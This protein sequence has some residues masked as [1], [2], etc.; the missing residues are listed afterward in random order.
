M[1]ETY[2]QYE[3]FIAGLVKDISKTHR[4]IKFLCSG[5]KC[6]LMG[7]LGQKHQVDVAFIDETFNPPKLVLIECKLK[8][9][10]YPVGP[11]VVKILQFNG[12]D[13]VKNPNY[14]DENLLIICSTSNFTSGAKKLSNA[15]NIKLERVHSC[16]DYT[17][18]YENIILCGV[19]SSLDLKENV[20]CTVRHPDG[21]VD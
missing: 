11:E 15:L 12:S 13:L 9:L 5:A 3:E 17:F 14:P 21:T 8:K 6:T 16:P 1:I 18:K 7:A 2:A 4:K 19:S 10:K 20:S